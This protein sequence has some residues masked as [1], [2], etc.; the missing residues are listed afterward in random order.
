MKIH[1]RSMLVLMSCAASAIL[2]IQAFSA[3]NGQTARQDPR[4]LKQVVQGFLERQTSDLSGDVRISVSD[5]DTRLNLSAC[6]APE[7]FLP[8]NGRLWGRTAVG[9]R[10]LAPT[11]WAIYM[12]ATVQIIDDYITP[13]HTLSSGQLIS[14]QDLLTLSGDL[15]ALPLGSVTHATDAIGRTVTRTLQA[16]MPIRATFLRQPRAVQQGQT[17]KIIARGSGFSIA[18]EARALSNGN[19]GQTVRARTP[20]GQVVSGLAQ[21]GGV[22][23]VMF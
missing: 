15:T 4:Q 17:V 7:A 10:C 6:V 1:L 16:G 21:A 14:A 11:P 19:A 18:T 12:T 3:S 5:P 9:V 2:P 13:A 8:P 20:S 23:E 22:V